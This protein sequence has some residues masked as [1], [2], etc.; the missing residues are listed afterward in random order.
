MKKKFNIVYFKDSRKMKEIPNDSIDLVV[1]SP[2]YFN[3]KDYFKDGKQIKIM[4]QAKVED[5]GNLTSFNKK[6]DKHSL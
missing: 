5:V 4:T 6:R 1:T 3:I 2:P